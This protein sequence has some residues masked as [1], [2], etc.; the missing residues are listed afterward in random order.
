MLMVVAVPMLMMVAVLMAMVMI[1]CVLM[2]SLMPMVVRHLDLPALGAK[3][4]M[5]L[6]M[7]VKGVRRDGRTA[8]AAHGRRGIPPLI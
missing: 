8:P 6:T 1:V 2:V 3:Q 7:V 4:A 5:W